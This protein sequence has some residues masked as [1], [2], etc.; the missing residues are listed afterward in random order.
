MKNFF[1]SIFI[2]FSPILFLCLGASFA[3]I[4]V[5][6][7][8]IKNSN[9]YD[10]PQNKELIFLGDSHIT[11]SVI[12]SLIPNSSNLSNLGEPYYYSFQKL[13]YVVKNQNIKYVV[14]GLSYHNIS[15]YYEELINGNI[16]TVFPP[17]IFFCLD[18]IEKLRVISW[19]RNKLFSLLRE[20]INSVENKCYNLEPTD[21]K[22]SF[23]TG[24]KNNLYNEKVI[25]KNVQNRIHSQFF[26]SQNQLQSFSYKNIY[27]LKKII[28]FCKE[29]NLKITL[30]ITPLHP[31]YVRLVP[32]DYR[33]E[34]K[35]IINK[36][37]V[38]LINL[39]NLALND[40]CYAHDGDHLTLKG[41]SVMT[42]S[43]IN[44]LKFNFE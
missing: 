2:F 14:L 38:Q 16:S 7:Y 33:S 12:D 39:E 37:N 20:L 1:K 3:L 31:E 10:I 44:C 18:F 32:Q 27:Y 13:K 42:D 34:L 8:V 43:L 6:K 19:N 25:I 35:E 24:F 17:K 36:N 22:Y 26:T 15:S 9:Q 41:A 21:N 23:S 4:M 30:L 28:S 11:F 29:N 5:S 40:S